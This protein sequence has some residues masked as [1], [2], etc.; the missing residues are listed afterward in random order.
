MKNICAVLCLLICPALASAQTI[1]SVGDSA[2]TSG[3]DF[4]T[5]AFQDPWD[6]NERT[7]IGWFLNGVDQPA[8][9][10]ALPV[11]TSGQFSATSTN[12]GPNIFLLE[13]GNP[14]A[15]R[16]GKI[17]TNYPINADTHK[18]IAFRMSVVRP[19]SAQFIWNR[20][21]IYDTTTTVAFNVATTPN[22]RIYLVDLTALTTAGDGKIPWSGLMRALRMN[23][24]FQPAGESIVLDWVRLV[25]TGTAS[26]CRTITWTGG[27]PTV[28]LYLVDTANTNLGIIAE[29][30][31]SGQASP[32]CTP[33]V[34]GYTYYAGA[35]APGTYRVGISGTGV[36][37]PASTFVGTNW[38]VNDIPTLTFTSPD[39]EGSSDDFATT[40]L[41]NPWDMNALTDLDL[42]VNV[43]SPQIRSDLTFETPAGASLGTQTVFYGTSVDGRSD[44]S[45]T[46][47]GDPYVDP[48]FTTKRGFNGRIDTNRYR[49]LTLE[50]GIPN[51]PRHILDGSIARIV[52]RVAG[53]AG[54]NVS[55][56]IIFNHR[57]GVNVLDKIIVDMADRTALPLEAGVTS[58][59]I[60]GVS[61][62]PGLDIFRVDPHEFTPATPFYIRRIKL[63]AFE[64][65]ATSYTIRWQYVDSNPTATVTLFY[66]ATNTGACGPATGTQIGSP[67]A[68]SAG[69]ATWT[70]SGLANG[71][72][73]I[74]ASFSDGTN[75]NET[76]AKWPIVVDSGFANRPNMFLNRSD[77]N[78]GVRQRA[79]ETFPLVGTSAQTVRVNLTD[80]SNACWTVDNGLPATYTVTIN[81]TGCGSGSFTVALNTTNP[82]NV[83]GLGEATFTVRETVAGTI[84]NS[85]QSV[86]SFHRILATSTVPFGSV[87]TPADNAIVSGSIAVTGWALDDIDITQVSIFRDPVGAEGSAQ[88]FIGNAVRVDDARPDLQAAFADAPFNYRAGWGYL[89]LTNFLPGGGDGSYTLRI[90][91][92]D[93]EGNT[94]PLGSRTIGG[95]NSTATR[96]FGAID[97]PPQ[98]E[99]ISGT[100]Y[101]NF[102]WVLSRGPAIA[103]PGLSGSASVTVLIDGAAVGSP[104]GW[105]NRADLDALF[106]A[107]IYPGV[108]HAAGVYTFNTTV[109][110]N[111]VHTIAWVVTASN[112]Q[113][114]GIGSRYFTIANG[115]TALTLGQERDRALAAPQPKFFGPDMGRA[116]ASVGVIAASGPRTVLGEQLGRIVVDGS[117]PGTTRYDA[118]LVANGTLSPLPI[119][120]SFDDRNGMLYWQPG[121]GYA[122]AYDFV[123]VRDGRE[124]VPVRVVLQPQRVRTPARRGFDVTFATDASA[125]GLR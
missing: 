86:H 77:L 71:T 4:A 8:S 63:A 124:R 52:W 29:A 49:I 100:S 121:V 53:E 98:G 92:T 43:T 48:L 39:P 88:I 30:V 112:G 79:N 22:Y 45:A 18:Y 106:P 73:Y 20:D 69:Q 93:R 105:T 6:M 118:Y 70:F 85:P 123:V 25:D 107:S 89:L 101:N 91:A 111:G 87:D 122:G 115:A 76:Y 81:G 114:D 56:D 103:S 97:T 60:N 3:N 116:A 47:I 119:G 96:P 61:S 57:E 125:S 50:M 64:R 68:A 28:N 33:V 31:S 66:S 11:F 99:T 82:F 24:S 42:I 90:Y 26:S 7:D 46:D 32:G 15:A 9:G 36:S 2:V 16:L 74:C 21:T 13:T 65:A 84:G 95:A 34:G 59:W 1:T 58:G 102:G 23:L 37:A 110:A 41:N 38:V 35:L 120:A 67:V 27:A 40:F 75:T 12:S 113:A 5:R 14:N 108:T 109:Y 62:K 17:G 19:S 78:F 117:R 10:L 104:F 55:D 80:G 94:V 72:Y 51:S 83:A 54:E 44:T